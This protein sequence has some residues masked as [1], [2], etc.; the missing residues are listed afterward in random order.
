MTKISFKRKRERFWHVHAHSNYS[1]KDALSS[2]EDMVATV[3][4]LGQRALALTDHGLMG[5]TVDLYR[6][7]KKYG[8]TPFP[9]T[10]IYMSLDREEDRRQRRAKRYHAGL[11][12]FTTEGYQNL[13][14]ISTLSHKNFYFKPLLDFGDFAEL[15]EQGLTRGVALTTGCFFGLVQQ[16]IADGD[17]NVAKDWVRRLN[18]YFDDVY[19][20]AQ[21]HN[22]YEEGHND[23]QMVNETWCIAQDLS[24]PMVVSQDSHYCHQYEK[25]YH[26]GMKRLVSWGD[27]PDDAVF[28]GDSFHLADEAWVQSHYMDKVFRSGIE[29]LDDLYSKHTLTIP[30]LE[31]YHYHVPNVLKKRGDDTD[32]Q[33]SLTETCVD[34]LNNSDAIPRSK[35]ALYRQRLEDEL[36]VVD[37]SGMAGYLLLV[38]EVVKE[39]ESRGIFT[40]T[41][42]SAEGSLICWLLGITQADPIKY[43]LRFE[44][45]LSKDRTKPPDIDLDIEDV[46]RDEMLQWLDQQYQVAQ[47]GTYGTFSVDENGGGSLLVA[48]L[49]KIR[50]KNPKQAN[51]I[52]SYYDLPEKDQRML[53]GLSEMGVLKSY[54]THAAGLV[55][56]DDDFDLE[57]LVPMMWIAS[58]KTM[59]T[60][61]AMKQVESMG[62]VKL[63][64]LGLKTLTALRRA[65]ELLG[66]DVADGF[67]WIPL[68]DSKTYA[69]IRRGDTGGVFQ[70][71]G[72]TARRGCKE[73]KVRNLKDVITL[74]ALYRPAVM[75]S[76]AKDTY[77]SRRFKYEQTPERHEVLDPLDETNG[78]L[79]FQ[80][81]VMDVVRNLGFSADEMTEF[82]AA[83]KASNKN[84]G[85]AG[86]VIDRYRTK[87]QDACDKRGVPDEDFDFLWECIE[88]FAEYGFNRAH[89]T[90]YALLAVRMAYIKQHHPLEFWTA[91]LQSFTGDKAKEYVKEVKETG[92]PVLRPAVNISGESWSIDRR[93]NAIRR[94]LSTI[95]GV[96]VKASAEIVAGYPYDSIED[97]IERT[98]SR[99]VTGGKSYAKDGTLNG[100]LGKLNDAGAL[101]ELR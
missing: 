69:M 52:K 22:I 6:A 7:C 47:I 57:G 40:Q 62:L 8:I 14:R 1:I 51:Q 73:M 39:C 15:H 9:G 19:V 10:E 98:D 3:S 75:S 2:V 33:E 41:R 67:D 30:Q 46:R 85:G 74:M 72:W 94:G 16:A 29:G 90:S 76:G 49:S 60:Q 43:N 50:Q 80:E 71:E 37:V 79:V 17:M 59:V 77:I 53:E 66:R 18:L 44:R 70:L 5:G 26:D 81:Q 36:D 54:G 95:K 63:D 100:V 28:P 55:V 101:K 20:E 27:D 58:S 91:M 64:L 24:L 89:A 38:R 56:T 42:G 61:Y 32:P 35:V 93:R 99:A 92:I 87:V 68:N 65:S 21:H 96:G 78:V 34:L 11:V 83:V 45:F 4:T 25:H 13:C 48:M 97:L 23:D 31:R 86:E 84:I 88:G 82:L 12:A